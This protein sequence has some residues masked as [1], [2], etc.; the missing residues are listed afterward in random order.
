M[1]TKSWAVE[2]IADSSGKFCGNGLRYKTPEAAEAAAKDLAARWTSVREW[3]VSPQ[4]DE[5]NVS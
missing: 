2:V 5:P 1:E 3:R 4:V